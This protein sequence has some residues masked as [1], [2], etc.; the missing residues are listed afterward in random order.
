LCG[1]LLFFNAEP[2]ALGLI[3]LIIIASAIFVGYLYDG[4]SWCQYFCPMYP[5]QRIFGEPRGLFTREAHTSKQTITQSMCRVS[6]SKK[7]EKSNCTGCQHPCID[8]DAEKSYWSGINQ[9][10]RKFLYYGYVGLVIGYFFYYNL[11]AGNW[12]YSASR[13]YIYKC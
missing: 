6:N 7:D 11:Y 2:W 13:W 10:S 4:K 1:R 9:P 5:V 3:C 12:N 8:I